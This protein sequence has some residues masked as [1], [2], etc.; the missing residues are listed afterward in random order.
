M[1]GSNKKMTQFYARDNLEAWFTVCFTEYYESIQCQD[2]DGV[3]NA[4][5]D[6]FRDMVIE[7]DGTHL[8]KAEEFLRES[9]LSNDTL[10]DAILHS[11]DWDDVIERFEKATEREP[12]CN[13]CGVCGEEFPKGQIDEFRGHYDAC[14]YKAP[15]K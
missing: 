5:A 13:Q 1:S 9:N 2:E 14:H 6:D 12:Y 11:V 7:R 15:A 3:W 10:V 8:E 4:E